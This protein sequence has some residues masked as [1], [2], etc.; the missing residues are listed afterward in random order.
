M[1]SHFLQLSAAGAMM[2][3]TPALATAQSVAYGTSPVAVMSCSVN[4]VIGAGAEPSL[5]LHTSMTQ[6]NPANRYCPP[7]CSTLCA[8]L[9]A[10]ALAVDRGPINDSPR[11]HAWCATRWYADSKAERC[12]CGATRIVNNDGT[13]HSGHLL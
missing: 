2:V 4:E 11:V 1:S 6:V 7:V 10:F 9:D 8:A 5:A 3:A 13:T 12:E